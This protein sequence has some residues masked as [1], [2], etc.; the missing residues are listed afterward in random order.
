MRQYVIDELRV[1]DYEK[2]KAWLDENY[3]EAKIPGIYWIPVSSSLL[4]DIQLSHREC[5]PHYFAIEIE[6][7]RLSC[8][9][10]IRTPKTLKC[11][12]VAYA[13]KKQ[14]DWIIQFADSIL[15]K[16]GVVF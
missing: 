13:S 9:L 11:S 10:L 7:N 12:C 5:Q 4:N 15:E 6:S 16:L 8:E 3:G 14:R 1:T 2:I